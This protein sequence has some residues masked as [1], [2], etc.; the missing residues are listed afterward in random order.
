MRGNMDPRSEQEQ[1]LAEY[2]AM[3]RAEFA[4]KQR[5]ERLRWERETLGPAVQKYAHDLLEGV[6]PALE[7]GE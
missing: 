2:K 3:L 7:L 1:R 4:F 6:A 5:V